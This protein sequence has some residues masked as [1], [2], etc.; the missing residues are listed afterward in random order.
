MEEM[1][2]PRHRLFAVRDEVIA[3]KSGGNEIAKD[4]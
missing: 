1:E 3:R 2:A 4:P